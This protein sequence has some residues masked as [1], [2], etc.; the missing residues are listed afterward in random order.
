MFATDINAFSFIMAAALTIF[1]AA[2]VTFILHFK[3]KKISM[4]ESMKAIE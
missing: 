1:F 2:I 4:V 3:L